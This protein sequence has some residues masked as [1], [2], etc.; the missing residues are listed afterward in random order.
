MAT[1]I[2]PRKVA[3]GP[4]VLVVD[5]EVRVADAVR[6]TLQDEGFRVVTAT[7]GKRA[8]EVAALERPDI[9][10]LDIVMPGLDGHELMSALRESGSVP[11]IFLTARTAVNERRD[12]LDGGAD[13]YIVKPFHADELAARVRAVLRRGAQGPASNVLELGNMQIDF[14]RRLLSR[15]GQPILLSRIEWLLLQYLA[16]NLG[17]VVLHT[18]LLRYVWGA[19]YAEDVQ[20]LR[21][22][23]SR[24]RAKLGSGT[25]RRGLIRTYVGVGYALEPNPDAGAPKCR[26][27]RRDPAAPRR[28]S[29]P[30][31]G[32]RRR[33]RG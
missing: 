6:L 16:R 30:G 9:A 12:G 18:D 11:V 4:L 22:C 32:D 19:A 21:V 15:N 25:G 23:V 2:P 28:A 5:D 8:L 33:S 14:D 24:L 1:A 27:A 13:D 10:V 26:R 20:I 7:D 3:S 29:T 31:C 17:K